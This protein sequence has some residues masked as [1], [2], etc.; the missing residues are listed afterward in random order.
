MDAAE[1]YS[2][3]RQQNRWLGLMLAALGSYLVTRESEYP[4]GSSPEMVM[5]PQESPQYDNAPAPE[6]M[7][8]TLTTY[9]P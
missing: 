8:A 1:V 7:L 2:Q 3:I 6:A 5:A 4:V 9:E